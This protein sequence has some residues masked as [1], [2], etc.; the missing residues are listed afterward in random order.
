MRVRKH[1][2]NGFSNLYAADRCRG[3]NL[4]W[5]VYYIV[6]MIEIRKRKKKTRRLFYY[7]ITYLQ[8]TGNI[9]NLTWPNN[10]RNTYNV[11]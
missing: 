8:T 4:Q 3:T 6:N 9:V 10:Y 1:L 7:Y 2:E 5:S 11:A